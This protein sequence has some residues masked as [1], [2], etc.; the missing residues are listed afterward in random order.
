[1]REGDADG[2][3]A[4]DGSSTDFPSK[5]DSAAATMGVFAQRVKAALRRKAAEKEAEKAKTLLAEMTSG[6]DGGDGGMLKDADPVMRPT[7]ARRPSLADAL[8]TPPTPVNAASTA[9]QTSASDASASPTTQHRRLAQRIAAKESDIDR[10][11]N[12]MEARQRKMTRS[13]D[14][15]FACLVYANPGF[16]PDAAPAVNGDSSKSLDIDAGDLAVVA[17]IS[18]EMALETAED[19]AR[20]KR[21]ASRLQSGVSGASSFEDHAALV[22]LPEADT[23]ELQL[24]N[25][26]NRQ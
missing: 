15:I 22:S 7:L 12:A 4:A 8:T 24:P 26:L 2:G 13:L 14:Q 23:P 16:D 19:A 18:E 17:C 10:R 1:M 5:A 25:M 3:A 20:I 21:R 6:N 9:K 11:L